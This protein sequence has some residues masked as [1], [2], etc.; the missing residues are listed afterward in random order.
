MSD[1]IVEPTARRTGAGLCK[2]AGV[3]A[4]RREPLEDREPADSPTTEVCGAELYKLL[5]RNAFRIAGAVLP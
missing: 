5:S 3:S 1:S 2:G 4:S